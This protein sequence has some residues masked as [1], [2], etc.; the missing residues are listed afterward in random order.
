MGFKFKKI[1]L[2]IVVKLQLDSQKMIYHYTA[3]AK[4]K[5]IHHIDASQTEFTSHILI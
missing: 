3:M 2:K 5:R 4:A 1:Q